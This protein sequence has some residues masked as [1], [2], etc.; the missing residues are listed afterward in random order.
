[1]PHVVPGE[2]E[3]RH[4]R[5]KVHLPGDRLQPVPEAEDAA[6]DDLV[7]LVGPFP[8]RGEGVLV[9]DG[10]LHPEERLARSVRVPADVIG[11]HVRDQDDVD[12]GR[13]QLELFE[14]RRQ[15]SFLLG[16]PVPE[17]PAGPTPVSTSS[18]R[19]PERRT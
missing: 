8:R 2:L 17:P 16:L 12:V 18:V 13:R 4:S 1:M 19:P 15:A 5:R 9:Q 14:R 11:V 7:P 10:V 6:P 3:G